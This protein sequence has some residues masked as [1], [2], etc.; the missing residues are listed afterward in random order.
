MGRKK[1]QCASVPEKSRHMVWLLL[2]AATLTAQHLSFSAQTPL[3]RA[4][5]GGFERMVP[6]KVGRHRE[7]SGL[8]KHPHQGRT[9][10]FMTALSTV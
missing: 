7:A 10:F 9:E 4:P 3:A 6:R 1:E 8:L 5:S 2:P